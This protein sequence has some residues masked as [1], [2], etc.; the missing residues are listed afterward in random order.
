MADVESELALPKDGVFSLLLQPVADVIYLV[1]PERGS[2]DGLGGV[3]TL[4][5]ISAGRYQMT[6]SDEAWV[7]A[8]QN[9]RRLPM[10]GLDRAAATARACA[11]ACSSR[12]RAVPLT[13]QIGGATVRRINIAVLRRRG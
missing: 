7:D 4:E 10:L 1:P 6:L 12:S 13:L 2:D 9:E 5:W 3:I 8:V 11:R